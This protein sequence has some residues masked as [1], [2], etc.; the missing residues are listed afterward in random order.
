[1]YGLLGIAIISVTIFVIAPNLITDAKFV[2]T[3]LRRESHSEH[4]GADALGFIGNLFYYFKTISTQ[5]GYVTLLPFT[6]GI[7]CIIRRP[8]R[9]CIPLLIGP[10][11]IICMSV[12]PLHWLRWGV[13]FYPFYM[14]LVSLGLGSMLS[15]SQLFPCVA[16][17]GMAALT[18]ANSVLTG[19]CS[20]RFSSL[21]DT[22][23]I[24]LQCCEE[25][26]ITPDNSF[27]E[28]YTPFCMGYSD[29]KV[30]GFMISGE[31]IQVKN[32]YKEK[33]FL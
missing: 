14:F 16:A 17:A 30:K 8:S 28:G 26:G 25:N 31:D 13:P 21:T 7:A 15:I 22:R 19:L 23:A 12:L 29:P 18:L 1:M 27:Y 32:A 24:A 4:L 10:F 20:V 2:I 11:F 33:S 3:A 9:C 5:L 6:V